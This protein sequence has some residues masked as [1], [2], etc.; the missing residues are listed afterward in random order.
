MVTSPIDGRVLRVVRD[1]AGPVA[2]G[3]PL[4]ELGDPSALE[5]IVDVLSI[6]AGCI[7]PGMSAELDGRGPAQPLRGHVRLV[8]PSGFTRISALGVEEQRVHVVVSLDA[9]PVTLGDGFR[10]EARVVTWRGDALVVPASAVFRERERDGV[11][12]SMRR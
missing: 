9:T 10:V 7:T 12:V 11:A 6:D 5:V 8:E 4:L 1:S 3:A 2:A